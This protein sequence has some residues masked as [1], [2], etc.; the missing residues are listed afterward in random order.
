MFASIFRMLNFDLI[1]EFIFKY[2]SALWELTVDMAPYLL[3]G[4]LFA[5]LL[6]VFLPQGM[7]NKYLGKSSF[8]SVLN[9]SLLGIPLPLCSCGVL[10]AGI[11]LYK[12]GASKGSSV[13]F[14]ISTPQTGIDSILVT[15]SMLGLPLAII[16][17]IAALI[18]GITG[19]LL[20]NK[21][22]KTDLEKPVIEKP[23][24]LNLPQQKKSFAKVLHYAFIEMLM[25]IA[26]WLII[27]LLIAAFISV[28]L[29]NNFFTE[30]KLDGFYGML[31]MLVASIPLYVCATASV[32]IAAVLLLKGIS[33]GALLVFLMAGPA[34][35][36]ATISVVGNN[37]GKKT[38]FAYLFS[39]IA[40]SLA[41]GLVMDNF[42]PAEWF[43]P[44]LMLHEHSH[45][46]LPHWF[47]VASA[48][49]LISL[50]V[51]GYFKVFANWL[52]MRKKKGSPTVFSLNI[53][54][55]EIGIEGMTCSKCKAKVE[56]G[57]SELK[58]VNL[59]IADVESGIL[60]IYGNPESI[61]IVKKRIEELGYGFYV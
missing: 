50:L 51:Y 22:E 1:M 59:A 29:P 34:T 44:V 37:L 38:L 4:F 54:A 49:L 7:M 47:S 2:F 33:P 57:I 60:K 11:S 12:N 58:D 42:L 40:G 6:K 28:I 36:A 9:A 45:G 61:E 20:T 25:D 16:R 10:P 13:S 15:W 39:I 52:K 46:L 18:T 14:L 19:G 48:L 43:M 31:I 5:G 30:F 41:F 21:L 17:P 53:P 3:L 32:P 8:K 26:K 35:N 27:G 23:K 24:T 56:K 55:M